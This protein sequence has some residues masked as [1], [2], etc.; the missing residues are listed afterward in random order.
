MLHQE[1]KQCSRTLENH[2]HNTNERSTKV[3]GLEERI[4]TAHDATPILRIYIIANES[5]IH[6]HFQQFKL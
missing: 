2:H 6:L 3:F 1:N 5:S 4:P